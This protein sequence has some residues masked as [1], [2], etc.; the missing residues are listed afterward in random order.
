M[1]RRKQIRHKT[2]GRMGIQ[3]M[4]IGIG[5]LQSVVGNE[6]RFCTLPSL[7]R[8]RSLEHFPKHFPNS[9]IRLLVIRFAPSLHSPITALWNISKTFPKLSYQVISLCTLPSL[10]RHR[11]LEHFPKHLQN[12]F[13]TQISGY[14]LS[15]FAPY[16]HSPVTA[17]WKISQNLV[18]Q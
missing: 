10:T 5:S 12:I 18:D 4:Q 11:S 1:G 3:R 17:L 13:Q 15:V 6:A 2:S 16:L 7:T 14:Q 9:A 8:H